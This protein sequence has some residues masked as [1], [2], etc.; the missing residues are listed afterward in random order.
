MRQKGTLEQETAFSPEDQ[1][2]RRH[3]VLGVVQG[4]HEKSGLDR[5]TWEGEVSV[6]VWRKEEVL[7]HVWDRKY[8]GLVR[9][10]A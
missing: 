9:R 8:T 2:K 7:G 6:F 10:C 3:R 4:S 5:E 1:G